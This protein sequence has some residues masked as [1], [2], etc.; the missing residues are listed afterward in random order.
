R[1]LAC[2]ERFCLDHAF[3]RWGVTVYILQAR[4]A[5]LSGN[6]TIARERLTRALEIA[7]PQKFYRAFLDDA[8]MVFSVIPSLRETSPTFVDQL[9]AYVGRA[10]EDLVVPQQPLTD[11]LSERELQ[12]L[13]LIAAGLSNREIA[14][15][16]VI[17]TGTVKRHINHIYSKLDVHSR[18]RAIARANELRLLR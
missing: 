9:L 12:V 1:W 6:Q 5:I 14:D 8:M 7:A 18:T 3:Y 11:P 2:L 15:E 17:A 4:A 10:E 13:G 16:L